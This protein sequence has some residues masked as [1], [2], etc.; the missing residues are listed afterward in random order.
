MSGRAPYFAKQR[1]S[2]MAQADLRPGQIRRPRHSD[3]IS[4]GWVRRQHQ[5]WRVHVHGGMNETA[6]ILNNLTSRS[7]VL[8]DDWTGHKHLRRSQH[9]VGDCRAPARVRIH[10]ATHPVRHLPRAQR[11]ER[12]LS[13]IV[14][15][16]V[17]VKEMG[18]KIVTLRK[19]APGGSTTVWHSRLRYRDASRLA[20]RA[21]E[22]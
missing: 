12:A 18:G 11:H 14:N 3:H 19:L 6:A 20:R 7:L 9:R 13:R 22:V 2:L 17:S 21:E 1:I 5:Q 4:H 10:A 16:N 15:V 8:L